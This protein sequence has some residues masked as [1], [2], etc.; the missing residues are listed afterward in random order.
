[1]APYDSDSSG[2]DSDG[3]YTETN[4]LLG[5]ASKEPTDDPVSQL[6]GYPTWLDATTPP[7]L[8][9][10]KCATCSA[11]P[12]LLLQLDANLPTHF[13][14]H[15]RRLYI[16][17]CRRKACRRKPG[18]V[19]AL[20]ATRV[21]KAAV[22]AEL[23]R[24]ADEEAR[25]AAERAEEEERKNKPIEKGLG[26]AL[27]GVGAAAAGANPFAANP[28]AGSGAAANANPF[29]SASSLAAKPAQASAPAPTAEAAAASDS[30]SALPATFAAKARI[31]ATTPTTSTTPTAPTPPHE[32]WPP[33][34]A[35]PP[36][37][38]SYHLDA[39]Y[40]TL[41]TEA[42]SIPQNTRLDPDA[43]EPTPAGGSSGAGKEDKEA[44]ESTLDKAF[45]RFADRLAQNPDQ[46]LRYEFR[47]HPLLYSRDDAV[48]KALTPSSHPQHSDA[49][50]R[51]TAASVQGIPRCANCNA[52]RVFELQLCPQ[53]I[54]ELEAEELGLEG[55]EWGTLIVGVCERDCAAPGVRDGEVGYV[56]EWVG[57]QW[58]EVGGRR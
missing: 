23:K 21:T 33:T 42:P 48:G 12:T 50:V 13:P 31:G 14:G 15:D 37:Y 16:F 24:S 7:S 2:D 27:F 26:E 30:T 51:T 1:M 40:E 9:L 56:E 3:E 19:R 46:V 53:A 58:E 20:R 10:A 43:A 39:D 38:P 45:Q 22:E 47:G 5:Y 49:K 57:V 44:F 29:A 6:G 35:L 28:F 32:P 4:V 36:P 11:P 41:S 34:S 54:A 55:M 52:N 8:A 18:S 25:K 17:A